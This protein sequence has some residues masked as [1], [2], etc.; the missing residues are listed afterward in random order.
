MIL[1]NHD[2]ADIFWPD[3]EVEARWSEQL[4]R[5]CRH[6]SSFRRTKIRA[7]IVAEEYRGGEAEVQAVRALA[8]EL[9]VVH[10]LA[11][12]V[13]DRGDRLTVRLSRRARAA[14]D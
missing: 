8:E 3:A 11:V 1:P 2:I 9:S 14:S 10:G 6:L 4:E 12:S 13:V 7:I 5:A